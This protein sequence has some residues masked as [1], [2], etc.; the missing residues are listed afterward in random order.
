MTIQHATRAPSGR[1]FAGSRSA[2]SIGPKISLRVSS[3]AST[4]PRP[5]N[6]Q[7]VT[8][9]S[10]RSTRPYSP[11]HH[12][13]RGI[14]SPPG[15]PIGLSGGGFSFYLGVGYIRSRMSFFFRS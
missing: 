12:D 4:R 15:A 5:I 14:P 7:L 1:P 8:R 10:G 6:W 11:G 9:R 3:G 2:S 13:Q